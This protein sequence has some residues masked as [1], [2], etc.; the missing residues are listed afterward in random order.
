MTRAQLVQLGAV[1][2]VCDACDSLVVPDIYTCPWC[3][4]Y[5]FVSDREKAATLVR[6]IERVLESGGHVAAHVTKVGEVL[7]VGPSDQDPTWIGVKL[8]SWKG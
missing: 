7:F 3:S 1:C 8:G 2:K 4:A 5:R 6:A